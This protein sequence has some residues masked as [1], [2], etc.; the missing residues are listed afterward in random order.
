MLGTQLQSELLQRVG[1]ACRRGTG[2]ARLIGQGG[3]AAGLE[4][5]QPLVSGLAADAEALSQQ[6]DVGVGLLGQVDKFATKRHAGHFFP[7]HG[8]PPPGRNNQPSRIQKCYPCVRTSVTYAPS[9]HTPPSTGR[10][11]SRTNAYFCL[12]KTMHCFIAGSTADIW[13]PGT[14]TACTSRLAA[15]AFWA[16]AGV[17]RPRKNSSL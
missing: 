3:Q 6:G 17:L 9:L 16:S 1:R 13:S 4:A 14:C 12:K 5:L 8:R 11:A 7:R 10:G 2:P 15:V